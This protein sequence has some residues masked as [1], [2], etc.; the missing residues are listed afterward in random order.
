MTVPDKYLEGV[1]SVFKRMHSTGLFSDVSIIA[2]GHMFKLH[3]IVLVTN[4]TLAGTGKSQL[5]LWFDDANINLDS[6]KIVIARMY[7]DFEGTQVHSANVLSLLATGCFFD[8]QP[9]CQLCVDFI[10]S[11]LTPATLNRYTA[12]AER[13]CY[14][15]YSDSIM[16]SCLI[17]L[18]KNAS[19]I[20][21]F[22]C[23]VALSEEWLMQRF[24][25]VQSI[26][27]AR[28]NSFHF[29]PSGNE[30]ES[31]RVT[32]MKHQRECSSTSSLMT[33]VDETEI[34]TLKIGKLTVYEPETISLED[35]CEIC[36]HKEERE[37]F[38]RFA[39]SRSIIFSSLSFSELKQ[40]KQTD[41][42]TSP[43]RAIYRGLWQQQE[44]R[45]KI[46][47]SSVDTIDLRISYKVSSA[48]EL[49]DEDEVFDEPTDSGSEDD[50]EMPSEDTETMD[51]SKSIV[52]LVKNPT[53]WNKMTCPPFRFGYEFQED[54]LN[55][56]DR[57]MSSKEYSSKHFYGGSMW[58][59]YIQ[60]LDSTEGPALGIY[61]QRMPVDTQHELKDVAHYV[62]NRIQAKVWFQIV[63]YFGKTCCVLESKPDLFRSTQSWG[64][65][66]TKMYKDVFGE[67]DDSVAEAGIGAR[68][69]K[70]LVILGQT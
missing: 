64:W 68:E 65:R 9:L 34:S 15:F 18:C 44:L 17:H 67:R 14:G 24:D 39:L 51:G 11:S 43:V 41:D 5:D 32:S 66:S 63:C 25:L 56:I 16:D 19:N 50:E 53:R 12:F 49:A 29:E 61:M 70:C 35:T 58:H 60:K 3:R 31:D 40:I 6:F 10:D 47:N 46:E 42:S 57:Y 62:D 52:A 21:Y 48:C 2:F 13:H 4:S 23:F 45:S 30:L 37:A 7:G 55:N 59:L 22:D 8:D 33:L 1:V 27:K 28:N 69:L 38:A 54:Q 20:C 26:I 36:S